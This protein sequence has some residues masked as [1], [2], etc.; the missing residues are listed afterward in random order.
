MADGTKIYDAGD[1]PRELVKRRHRMTRVDYRP[2]HPAPDASGWLA[3][4][5][6]AHTVWLASEQPET[7]EGIWSGA[8]NGAF[9]TDLEPDAAIGWHL[10]VGTEELYLV[11]RGT[12]TVRVGRAIDDAQEF[13]L[14]EGDVHRVPPGWGHAS[15]AGPDGARIVVVEWAAGE[16]DV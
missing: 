6:T 16:S 14:T 5:G 2:A 3:G 8:L 4:S 7:A 1:E 9:D 12:L 15:V 13:M 10:H 11:L